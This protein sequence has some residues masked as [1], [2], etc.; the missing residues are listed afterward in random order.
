MSPVVLFLLFKISGVPNIYLKYK[1][2]TKILFFRGGGG[3]GGG[4][5]GLL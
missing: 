1:N 3:G 4:G 5:R 2:I